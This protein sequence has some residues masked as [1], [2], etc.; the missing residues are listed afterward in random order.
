MSSNTLVR[1]SCGA[2]SREVNADNNNCDK[3]H[4]DRQES[5]W[6]LED[7]GSANFGVHA[8]QYAKVREVTMNSA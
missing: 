6:A 8:N 3:R 7:L 2:I 4:H 5:A 1:L